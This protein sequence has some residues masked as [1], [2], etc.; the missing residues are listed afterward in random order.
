[1]DVR[2]PPTS[3]A[4]AGGKPFGS[5]IT[6]R[7]LNCQNLANAVNVDLTSPQPTGPDAAREVCPPTSSADPDKESP[8]GDDARSSAVASRCAG[9]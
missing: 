4:I 8:L 2:F 5:L 1:M 6:P 3:V 9:D 7:A